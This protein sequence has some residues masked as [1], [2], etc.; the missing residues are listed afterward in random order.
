MSDYFGTDAGN[1]A[2]SGLDQ[3][4]AEAYASG[5]GRG[6]EGLTRSVC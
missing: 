5:Q 2:C 1:A 6:D 4:D 3:Y